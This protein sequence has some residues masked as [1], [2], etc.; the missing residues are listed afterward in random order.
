MNL[1]QC[2]F[3]CKFQKDGYCSLEEVAPVNSIETNCPHY[4]PLLANKIEHFA[5]TSDSNKFNS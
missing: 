3:N 5:N 2:A 1:I 4:S